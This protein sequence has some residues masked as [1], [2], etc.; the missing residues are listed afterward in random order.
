MLKKL[1]VILISIVLMISICGVTHAA[2]LKTSLDIIQKASE[3]KNLENDQG[4]I[5]KTIV[6]SD[7]EKGEV[8]IDV[9][10]SNTRK[11]EKTEG[12]KFENTEIYLIVSENL[13]TRGD[14]LTSRLDDIA[15]LCSNVFGYDSKTKIGIIGIKGQIRDTEVVDG[16]MVIKENDQGTVNGKD[17]DAE[18]VAEPSNDVNAIKTAIQNMN[19]SKTVYYTNFQAAIKLAAKSYSENVNKILISLYDSVPDV[20]IGVHSQVSHGGLFSLYSTTEEAVTAKHEQ[21]ATKTSKEILTLKA[22]NISFLLLR[23]ADTSYDETWYDVN[24]GEKSLDF[25]G[26][27]Y[28]QKLYGTIEKPIYGKIYQFNEDNI[29]KIIKENIAADVQEIIQKYNL[30]N[31]KIVD[32]FPKD[33]IDNFEFSYVEKPTYGTVTPKI[34]TETS[35]ITWDIGSLKGDEVASLKYKLK[36]KD[37]KNAKLLNKEISTNEKIVLTYK[38]NTDKNYT[39]TLSSSPKIK[40]TEVKETTPEENTNANKTTTDTTI[41]N[42]VIPQTGVGIG[43]TVAIISVAGVVGCTFLMAKKY[44]NM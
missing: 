6:D 7:S 34:D 26:S 15:T 5:S 2:D 32:Y 44:K 33:I 16:K 17:T 4:F 22:K 20:A 43:L 25:D 18:I 24:T 40:L 27:P 12:K 11:D 37:M 10:L 38:D 28:V 41:S 42:K 3:T 8:T 35:T 13:A 31:V 23:P 39:V 36:I 1:S 14:V 30:S 19:S 21:I 29:D 9:K